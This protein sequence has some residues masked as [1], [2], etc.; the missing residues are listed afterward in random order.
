MHRHISLVIL[1]A[2]A[3]AVAR[4]YTVFPSHSLL[5]VAMPQASTLAAPAPLL[6]LTQPR[7]STP[8]STDAI[9]S[10]QP[11]QTPPSVP[12]S[13][14]SPPQGKTPVSPTVPPTH[15]A[16]AQVSLVALQAVG[17]DAYALAGPPTIS[18]ATID[19]V[20][21]RYNSPMAGSGNTIYKL[22]VDYGIDPVFCL[23]F[24]VHESA[25][26][27]R[28]EAVLT[29]NVGNIRAQAGFASRDGYRLYNTWD[30]SVRD[31]YRLIKDVYIGQWQLGTVDQ[32]VP[33]YA[34]SSDNN[35]V[36]AYI[37]DVETLVST[38]RAQNSG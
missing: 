10:I 7:T 4:G 11:P 19:D 24:F 33:V 22:G 14:A 34:P 38:W 31:W 23:A 8:K 32:I 18:V 3:L 12:P 15:Q 29:R 26:G 21:A 36:A 1:V 27:T 17:E 9:H 30:E 35:D 2:S 16:S 6:V 25:A 13:P 37:S 28:G 5:L 20:L